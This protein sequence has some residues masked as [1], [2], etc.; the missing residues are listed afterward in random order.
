MKALII[1][2]TSLM[3][4]A[5]FAQAQEDMARITVTGTGHAE[6]APDMVVISLGVTKEAKEAGAALKA[7]SEATAKVLAR[8]TK[9]GIGAR[10]IQTSD[11]SL[12]PVWS[13]HNNAG[14]RPE[15]TE[16]TATNRV[17]VRIRDLEILGSILDAVVREGANTFNGL[18]FT[19]SEPKPL[20]DLARQRAVMDAKDKAQ[21]LTEAAGVALGRVISISE[22]NQGGG[23]NPLLR[24]AFSEAAD[25][26]I[27]A[28]EVGFQNSVTMVFEIKQ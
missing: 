1:I 16:F 26:P 12:S 28:G 10:D 21:L 4:T 19:V 11:L 23:P 13:R 14:A 2:A 15:I 25:V 7:T 8:L 9:Q 20:H 22:Q 5:G 6:T 18:Q 17:T 24:K 3:L 27:A